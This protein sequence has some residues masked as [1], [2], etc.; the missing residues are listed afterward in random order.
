MMAKARSAR[1]LPYGIISVALGILGG[2]LFLGLVYVAPVAIDRS[3]DSG[4]MKAIVFTLLVIN[5]LLFGVGGVSGILS[6]SY[7]RAPIGWP[8]VG[9]F[10]SIMG[11]F[12]LLTLG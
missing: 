5:Y 4:G 11:F 8:V 3:A 2:I 12:S 10:L 9:C 6:W 7:E 1:P